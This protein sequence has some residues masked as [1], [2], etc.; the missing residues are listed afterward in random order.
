MREHH[1]HDST[2]DGIQTDQRFIGKACK[3]EEKLDK[4]SACS[5]KRTVNVLDDRSFS[6]LARKVRDRGQ[7]RR[8]EQ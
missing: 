1:A 5:A 6:R 8:D 3:R 7:H 2:H 4:M